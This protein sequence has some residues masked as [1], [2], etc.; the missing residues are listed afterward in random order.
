MT[1]RS[2][3]S[4][5][6]GLTAVFVGLCALLHG[7]WFI[8]GADGLAVGSRHACVVLDD[9]SIKVSKRDEGRGR[10]RDK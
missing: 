3:G 6:L 1:M 9:V 2:H 8:G 4:G 7:S 10:E 5:G